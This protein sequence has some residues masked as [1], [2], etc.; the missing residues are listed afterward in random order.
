MW[1]GRRACAPSRNGR[2]RRVPARRSLRVECACPALRSCRRRDVGRLHG[3]GVGDRGEEQQQKGEGAHEAMRSFR[4]RT[5]RRSAQ[6]KLKQM[7]HRF[8]MRFLPMAFAHRSM[9]SA[10]SGDNRSVFTGAFVFADRP[11][12]LR[13]A[14]FAAGAPFARTLTFP[15]LSQLAFRPERSSICFFCAHAGPTNDMRSLNVSHRA[16]MSGPAA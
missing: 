1:R 5:L 4:K 7:A 10:R 6:P 16:I 14:D 12:F 11:V 2:G 3:V 8:G 13:V 9:R 15:A